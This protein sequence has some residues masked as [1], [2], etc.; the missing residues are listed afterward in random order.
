MKSYRLS[1]CEAMQHTPEHP[2]RTA[3]RNSAGMCMDVTFQVWP[4][5]AAMLK[6]IDMQSRR[7]S[8]AT[9]WKACKIPEMQL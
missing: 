2:E 1:L 5:R 7:A 8:K 3:M 9:D 4:S 6:T